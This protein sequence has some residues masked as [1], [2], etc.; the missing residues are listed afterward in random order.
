MAQI[1]QTLLFEGTPAARQQAGA[2]FTA[3]GQPGAFV[4]QIPTGGIV[5]SGEVRIA[6]D[7]RSNALVIA[8]TKD[9]LA[10]IK[11]LV[12]ELDK[13]Y[14]PPVKVKAFELRYADAT[15]VADMLTRMV[16]TSGTQQRGGFGFFFAGIPFEQRVLGGQQW[17]G[18]QQNV[19]VADPRRNAVIVTTTDANMPIFEQLIAELENKGYAYMKA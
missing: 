19:I 15:Q 3:F 1:L 4:S 11:Q 5:R 6:A 14:L 9:N 8:A 10:L 18:F 7:A 13:D 17:L 2:R 12:A 16:Q